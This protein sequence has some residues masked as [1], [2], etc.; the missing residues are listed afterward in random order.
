MCYL[1]Y[2]IITN[3]ISAKHALHITWGDASTMAEV[4][5]YDIIRRR[6]VE[7]GVGVAYDVL[8]REQTNN[9]KKTED[10]GKARSAG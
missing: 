2:N 5:Q 6:G 1:Q 10:N 4:L 8:P 9:H 7:E 3:L